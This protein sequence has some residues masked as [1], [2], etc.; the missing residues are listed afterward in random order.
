M[1]KIKEPWQFTLRFTGDRIELEGL[2]KPGHNATAAGMVTAGLLEVVGQPSLIAQAFGTNVLAL[3]RSLHA[4]MCEEL[5]VVAMRA[6]AGPI[7]AEAER[8]NRP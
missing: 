2:C 7:E 1:A 6:P 3:D 8:E 4:L 5:S